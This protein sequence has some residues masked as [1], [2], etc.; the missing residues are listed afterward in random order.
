MGAAITV[1]TPMMTARSPPLKTVSLLADGF[2]GKPR[3]RPIFIYR[4]DGL[5]LYGI[6]NRGNANEH[7]SLRH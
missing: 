3:A 7:C 4:P 6:A 5:F 2:K 1:H